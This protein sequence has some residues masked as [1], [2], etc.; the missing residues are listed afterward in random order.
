MDN[1]EEFRPNK[2]KISENRWS[3]L[4]GFSRMREIVLPEDTGNCLN[5]ANTAK[6]NHRKGMAH[7]QDKQ[8]CMLL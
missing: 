8:R 3:E 4:K 7:F 2:E 5:T 1:T 6:S